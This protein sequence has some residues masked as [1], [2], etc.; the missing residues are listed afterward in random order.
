[1]CLKDTITKVLFGFRKL[2][3]KPFMLL[4]WKDSS[5]VVQHFTST[6]MASCDVKFWI[7][8]VLESHSARIIE[9]G[10]DI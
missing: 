7:C 1:M 2:A 4:Q 5:L 6:I 3:M 8:K 9:C 10:G